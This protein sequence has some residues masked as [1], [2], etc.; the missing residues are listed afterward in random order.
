M[1]PTSQSKPRPSA[2]L[3]NILR[4]TRAHHP[5]FVLFMGA[6]ASV[7]SG[8]PSAGALGG[9]WRE[10]FRTCYEKQG[11]K[12]ESQPWYNNSEEYS[13]LFEILY[14]QQS[15]RREFIE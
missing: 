3:I 4:D 1:W 15:Q 5:N 7:T 6:G 13:R 9:E 2:H 14:D 12:L 8:V 10:K 11:I